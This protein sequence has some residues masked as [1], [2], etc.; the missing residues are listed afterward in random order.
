MFSR[1][2]LP[3]ATGLTHHFIGTSS[4]LFCDFDFILA[5]LSLLLFLVLGG[6]FGYLLFGEGRLNLHFG[7]ESFIGTRFL[8]TKRSNN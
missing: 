4:D 7:Y 6:S 2:A 3:C 1:R 8:M 5:Q